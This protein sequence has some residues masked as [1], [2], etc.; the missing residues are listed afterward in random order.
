M[1]SLI[2]IYT[3]AM[4]S[5]QII[6]HLQLLAN[7][8]IAAHSKRFFKT[9]KGEYGEGDVFLGIRVPVIRQAVRQFKLAT[10]EDAELLLDSKYHEVRLFALLLLVAH[11]QVGE[12]AQQKKIYQIYLRNTHSINNWDLVDSSAPHIVGGYLNNR[13][14]SVL[15]KL[16]KSA[17]LWERRIATLA[18]YFFIKQK[19]YATSL[20]VA[21]VLLHDDQDL[22]HKAVG[23]M[24]REIGK[25]DLETETQYLKQHY[26]QMPRTMLRYAIEKFEP[27]L[28]QQYLHGQVR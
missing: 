4:I 12:A 3:N 6:E 19:R 23:W 1:V 22:I 21:H 15:F 24:L 13:D 28:R 26:K 9:G 7:P 2:V 5:E 17:S 18:T 27:A 8:E 10:I 20:Q 16:A 25:R 14:K 11:F